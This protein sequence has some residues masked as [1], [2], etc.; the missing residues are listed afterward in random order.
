M[1][2]SVETITPEMAKKY[3]LFNTSNRALRKRI[4]SMYAREM[5]AGNWRLTHQGVAFNCDGTLLDGQHRLCAI[6]ESG[7]TVQMLVAR[8]VESRTQLVMDDHA[9][10]NAGDALTL[11]RNEKITQSDV[12]VIR[13][14]IELSTSKNTA[15]I[16][17]KQELNAVL[18]DFRPAINFVSEVMQ[19]NERGVTSAPVKAAIALAWFYA[20]DLPRLKW[21]CEILTGK[22]LPENN[23]DRAAVVLREW[24]LRSGMQSSEMRRD[25]FKKTQRAIVAFLSHQDV[26]KLYGTSV[27]YPWPLVDPFRK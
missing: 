5:R 6:V 4:V 20:K 3:L 1:D 15:T 10:R 12:A 9:K 13:G 7:V 8:G 25:G 18:D 27:Y 22:Q 24:L 21:F 16:L 23:G 2:L 11:V 26:S 17:T 19:N 14:A